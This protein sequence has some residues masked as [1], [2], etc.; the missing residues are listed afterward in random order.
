MSLLKNVMQN[1]AGCWVD[2]ILW[3]S[4]I[5]RWLFKWFRSNERQ[6][7]L[8]RILNGKYGAEHLQLLQ[9]FELETLHLNLTIQLY[10]CFLYIWQTIL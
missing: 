7:R 5:V 10:L 3:T 8:R 2:L 1:F 4:G 6:K 9:F